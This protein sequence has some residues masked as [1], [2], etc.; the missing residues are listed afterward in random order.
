MDGEMQKRI[1]SASKKVGSISVKNSVT[2][3]F[4]LVTTPYF[5]ELLETPVKSATQQLSEY[6]MKRKKAGDDQEEK[7]IPKTEK[8]GEIYCE[9]PLANIG[10]HRSAASACGC[11]P[12]WKPRFGM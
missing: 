9:S 7:A 8:D 6:S 12:L 5:G 2:Q 4:I 1:T 10:L 3:W 11:P